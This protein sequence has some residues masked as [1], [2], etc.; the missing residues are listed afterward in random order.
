MAKTKAEIWSDFVKEAAMAMET[1]EP[2]NDF[3]E[4]MEDAGFELDFRA[5]N[6]RQ[7]LEKTRE[8]GLYFNAVCGTTYEVKKFP[9][10]TSRRIANQLRNGYSVDRLK[11]VI[12]MLANR[13]KDTKLESNL[14]LDIVFDPLKF[15]NYEAQCRIR[16]VRAN[17]AKEAP[18]GAEVP[19]QPA[20]KKMA[21]ST[22]E[23]RMQGMLELIEELGMFNYKE[24]KMGLLVTIIGWVYRHFNQY[25][26]ELFT[27]ELKQKAYDFAKEHCKE[28]EIIEYYRWYYQLKK[29]FTVYGS[30]KIRELIKVEHFVKEE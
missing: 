27:A 30:V 23:I 24:K 6:L 5:I 9:N 26:S 19:Q 16:P 15:Y 12:L 2:I 4:R 22:P 21:E 11:D 20:I 17:K 25:H 1:K 18:A 14:R 13:F 29:I 8:I 3:I 28:P 7:E 10:P